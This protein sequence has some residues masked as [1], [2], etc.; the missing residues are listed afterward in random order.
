MVYGPPT[1]KFD[2]YVRYVILIQY[3]L[4]V[5]IFICY[6][7]NHRWENYIYIYIYIY[8]YIYIYIFIS[9]CASVGFSWFISQHT[10]MILHKIYSTLMIFIEFISHLD[11]YRSYTINITLSIRR[12]WKC[13][14][15]ARVLERKYMLAIGLVPQL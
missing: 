10:T 2:T 7:K 3:L 1:S 11:V 4:Y 13:A 14:P 15:Q 5:I 8:T 12:D 9:S 6:D